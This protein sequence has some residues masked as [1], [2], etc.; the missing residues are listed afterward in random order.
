MRLR[1]IEVFHAVYSHG[2]IST[3]ARALH[4]S[5]PSVSKVLKHAEDQL[6]FSLFQRVKG[7]LAPTDEA[8]A[9]FQEVKEVYERLESLNQ[10]ARNLKQGEGGH[11]RIAILPALGLGV[12]PE[13]VTR[14]RAAHPNV[15]F[16]FRTLHYDEVARGLYG[17]EVDMALAYDAIHLPRIANFQIGSGE[18]MMVF[19]R[20]EMGENAPERIDLKE[21][22][23]RD[24]VGSGSSGPVSEIFSREVER[25]GLTIREPITSSTFYMS[26]SLVRHGV[27]VAVV[28]EFTARSE[29]TDLV[30]FRPLDPPLRFG[31]FCMHLEDRPLSQLA[32]RFVA[33][34]AEVLA[35]Q[36]GQ[37]PFQA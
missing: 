32:E 11:I 12:A 33:T 9:L 37:A 26:A 4:V 7:R 1:H 19:P 23:T 8:H 16:D 17:H 10:A 36:S 24:Y 6:G 30:E 34:M 35:E 25:R 22:E 27:G 3:A 18:L 15:T 13:A 5:Q 31:V 20:G 28:D 14:F 2:S 29:V 21:L